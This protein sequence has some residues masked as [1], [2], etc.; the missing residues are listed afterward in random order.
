MPPGRCKRSQCGGKDVASHTESGRWPARM[1]RERELDM[2]AARHTASVVLGPEIKAQ[3]ARHGVESYPDECCGILLGREIDGERIIEQVLP[4][5]NAWDESE[6]GNRFLIGPD[7]V[8]KAERA[9]RR[10]GLGV[11]GFYHSHPDS[12]AIPSEFD[13]EHAWPWYSYLIASIV[14]GRCAE[15]VAW[16]LRDDRSSYDR[17]TLS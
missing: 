14:D 15:I 4:I 3:I 17:L 9:A 11:L 13:R 12:P 1:S 6:R 8:L 2:T 10:A 16:Q 7:D 5:E